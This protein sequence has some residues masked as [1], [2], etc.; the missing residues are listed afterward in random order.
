MSD[1]T[2]GIV[3]CTERNRFMHY[4]RH[5]NTCTFIWSFTKISERNTKETHNLT[6][7]R[8]GAGKLYSMEMEKNRPICAEMKLL[9]RK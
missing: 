4:S 3:S 1:I 7:A 8:I 5:V 6:K 2:Q 9:E